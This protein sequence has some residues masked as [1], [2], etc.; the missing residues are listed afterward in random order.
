[1]FLRPRPRGVSADGG[2]DPSSATRRLTVLGSDHLDGHRRSARVTNHVAQRLPQRGQQLDRRAPRRSPCRPARRRGTRARTR[3]SPRRPGT[4]RAPGRASRWPTRRSD[5]SPKIAER[6]CFT[7]R[8]RSSTA[9]S[10]R[11]RAEVGP[12]DSGRGPEPSPGATDPVANSRWITVSWRS[13][14][15][16]SRSSTSASSGPGP[17]GGR[18]RWRRRRRRRAPRRAPRRPR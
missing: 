2:P 14:A 11:V 10:M 3:A 18:S 15:I 13:R 4:A 17:A 16:R 12:V 8:S 1:M 5:S 6:M 9:A 7:V